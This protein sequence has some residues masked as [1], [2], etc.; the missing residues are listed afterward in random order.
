[1][2][3]KLFTDQMNIDVFH[4]ILFDLYDLYASVDMIYIEIAK[5]QEILNTFNH[6]YVDMNVISDYEYSEECIFTI[7][8][9]DN[10][11]IP[12][13][14]YYNHIIYGNEF[15][16]YFMTSDQSYDTYLSQV[17][18]RHI[19]NMLE[20]IYVQRRCFDL[21]KVSEILNVAIKEL[22]V[23]YPLV[24]YRRDSYNI[25]INGVVGS[26]AWNSEFDE[27]REEENKN[28]DIPSNIPTITV[29]TPEGIT[30]NISET[31]PLLSDN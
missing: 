12:Y 22:V 5:L 4:T 29:T 7:L 20:C 11:I 24:R 13:H 9:N 25:I 28:E 15:I 6:L 19:F 26:Y 23:E 31:S 1:M 16:S 10:T 18:S 14:Y 2:D 17:I 3:K 27:R 30:R 21:R 8:N